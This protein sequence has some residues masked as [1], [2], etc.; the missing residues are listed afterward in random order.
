MATPVDPRPRSTRKVDDVPVTLV[1]PTSLN[2]FEVAINNSTSTA[3][4]T[5]TAYTPQAFVGPNAAPGALR[6]ISAATRNSAGA[7]HAWVLDVTTLDRSAVA[8]ILS[9][10]SAD[11]W[12]ADF[13]ARVLD[14]DLFEPA[15]QAGDVI[16]SI[17]WWDA[18]LA[19]ALL[20]Q[21]R[22]GFSFY[23]GLAW[24][25]EWYL[26]LRA[27]GKGTTQ[28]SYNEVDPLSD[29]QVLYA[30]ADA[31]ETLW[32]ADEIRSRVEQA[33]LS[34]VCRL[35][36]KARPFLDHM[37]RVGLPFDW[38]GWEQRLERM[39]E[40]RTQVSSDLAGLTGGGQATLF[41]ETLEPSWNPGSERQAK[42][43]LNK[44][45]AE[46]VHAW[47]TTKFGEARPL[48]PTD[49]LTATVLSDIGGSICSSLLEYRDLTKVL[50]TYGESIKEHID[51]F[52]RMHSEYLQVVGTN[53]GRLASRRPNAQNF[54]PKMKEHIK[55]SDPDRVFVYSDLSQAELRFATQVAGDDNLRKAFIAGE[56]IHSATAERMFGVNMTLLSESEPKIFSEYRDKAKRINFG[57][58]YGQRGGGLARSLSQAGVETNDE[59]GRV[60]LEQYLSAYP[61]IASWVNE[62]DEFV[63]RL[64][65]SHDQVDW[66]LTLLLHRTWPL[67]RQAV[68]QHRDEHR[69]WPRAEEV[70]ARL[71]SPWTIEEV[72]WSLSFEASVVIDSE[73]EVFGFDSL[74]QS[75][76]R[77]Q[78]TFHTEGVL[79]QAAQIII[80]SSKDGPRLVR[81]QI[82]DR[83]NL[84]L[85]NADQS[86]SSAEITKIL[87]D[88]KVRRAVIEQVE[89]TM[90]QEAMNLLLN[91]S[92]ETRISQMA[93][94]YRNAP[95]QGG[96]ADIMLEAYGLLHNRL[97]HFDRALGVQTV[98]DSVVVEC[99][100]KDARLVASTV[101]NTMEEAMQIWCPDI[102]AQADTDIRNSLSDHDIVETI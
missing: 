47:S 82:S 17:S 34:E 40:R 6:V 77:Q 13:D 36:Q 44:W 68:R 99:N 41:G 90:G 26:G 45:S 65:K 86:L 15:S 33:G 97:A 42:D 14:R 100:R 19:D 46:E 28:L 29:E 81:E 55:P 94:A 102:P 23:H 8:S 16:N 9:G 73:G 64:A 59:E 10:T 83:Y 56:D 4:D 96:V 69:N 37:Q 67:V 57:I 85:R 24:A 62:R 3:I 63:D 7:E 75:G 12:N 98:H 1:D 54:S 18:Q 72:A 30:A 51:D 89:Q 35:E 5:E 71:G 79:E 38:P 27:E 66:P 50:S 25:V 78:F 52:G 21:G 87:E 22:T 91:R 48:L 58:V 31:V 95:I 76:R 11:A 53:T 74:T 84:E 60:L 88:R 93:N 20:H 61:Q 101:K 49:P 92:L 32:V 80:G 2:A 43:A 39:E 70:L